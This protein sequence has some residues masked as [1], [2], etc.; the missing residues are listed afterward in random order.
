MLKRFSFVLALALV[1][2]LPIVTM[3]CSPPAVAASYPLTCQIGAPEHVFVPERHR[4]SL[5]C[6]KSWPGRRGIA[7]AASVL[8]LIGR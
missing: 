6:G 8:G 4:R 3:T 5:I 1:V 7:T 2:G